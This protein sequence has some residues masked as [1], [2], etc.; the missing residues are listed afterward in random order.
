MNEDVS[1]NQASREIVVTIDGAPPL[2]LKVPPL[3][4]QVH[5]AELRGRFV[6][7]RTA[8]GRVSYHV[9]TPKHVKNR[10]WRLEHSL[11]GRMHWHSMLKILRIHCL[12]DDVV[13]RVDFHITHHRYSSGARSPSASSSRITLDKEIICAS[14]MSTSEETISPHELGAAVA[15]YLFLPPELAIASSNVLVASIALL[16]RRLDDSL[17]RRIDRRRFDHPLWRR[18]FELRA[19]LRPNA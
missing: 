16:D 6:L 1:I 5:S 19:L 11:R 7:V 9:D 2:E 12:L 13:P 4:G 10:T 8:R 15:E 3:L 18:F 14:S 17:L